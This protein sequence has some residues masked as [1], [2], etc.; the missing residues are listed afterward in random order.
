MRSATAHIRVR[1]DSHRANRPRLCR[2]GSKSPASSKNTRSSGSVV[3]RRSIAA[4]SACLGVFCSVILPRP[5]A[6]GT[7]RV[8]S[9]TGA[10]RFDPGAAGVKSRSVSFETS[11]SA[12]RVTRATTS[13]PGAAFARA[14]RPVRSNPGTG[15]RPPSMT[16]TW[17]SVP[18]AVSTA[19]SRSRAGPARASSTPR[20]LHTTLPRSSLSGPRDGDEEASPSPTDHATNSLRLSLLATTNASFKSLVSSHRVSAS[21]HRSIGE[22]PSGPSGSKGRVARARPSGPI[23][24]RSRSSP[25]AFNSSPRV[26]PNAPPKIRVFTFGGRGGA[27]PWK[28]ALR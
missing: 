27:P 26:T 16:S 25:R 6:N 7:T 4:P 2:A 13:R 15:A 14:I 3:A 9:A 28:E 12:R 24:V 17:S 8:M 5:S 1:R 11:A 19:K 10:T 23:T 21:I 18:S 20:S 22:A